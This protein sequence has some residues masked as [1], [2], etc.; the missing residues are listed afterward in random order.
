MIVGRGDEDKGRARK[1]KV[2]QGGCGTCIAFSG[3][4]LSGGG[5]GGK[6]RLCRN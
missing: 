3:C 1:G 2:K 5:G 6:R 4:G